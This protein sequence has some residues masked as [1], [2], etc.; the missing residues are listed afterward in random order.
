MRTKC[1]LSDTL[2]V[3]NSYFC[4]WKKIGKWLLGR[5]TDAATST[6]LIRIGTTS[7]DTVFLWGLFRA[8]TALQSLQKEQTQTFTDLGRNWQLKTRATNTEWNTGIRIRGNPRVCLLFVLLTNAWES[9]NKVSKCER[10]FPFSHS[11][12]FYFQTS[13]MSFV[14]LAFLP[15]GNRLE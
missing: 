7:E 4:R 3:D 12:A 2:F 9:G 1:G 11:C 6:E 8:A 14:Q 13:V 15:T 5:T 10:I